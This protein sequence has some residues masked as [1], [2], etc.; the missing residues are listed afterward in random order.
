VFD[1][2]GL[3]CVVEFKNDNYEVQ[4]DWPED[5]SLRG[6]KFVA[7]A[8]RYKSETGKEILK[9]SKDLIAFIGDNYILAA[10]FKKKISDEALAEILKKTY[11]I[12][13]A[14][15]SFDPTEIGEVVAKAIMN[16]FSK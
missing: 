3:F 4:I 1:N 7:H 10:R 6:A 11:D 14:V 15:K 8:L 16:E 13:S 9:A 2:T 5:V 12:L